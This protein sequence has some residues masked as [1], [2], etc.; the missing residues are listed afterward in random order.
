MDSYDEMKF[1]TCGEWDVIQEHLDDLDN[2]GILYNPPRHLLFRSLEL[3]PLKEVKVCIIG[4]DPYPDRQ[5]CTGVAFSI[6]KD[7]KTMP[8]TL[9]IILTEYANDL[10]YPKPSNGCLERWCEQGVLLWNAVPSCLTGN[11]LS[12][13]SW[14]EWRLLTEELIQVLGQQVVVFVFVGRVAGKLARLVNLENSEVLEVAHPAAERYG[15][16][17]RDKFSGS[18]IFTTINDRLIQHGAGKIDWRLT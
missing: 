18:R 3:C 2:K 8:P 16:Q 1:W 7:C 14:P 4:Q 17:I 6:P 9:N 11:S 5:Y 12:H 13:N 15:K 10:H